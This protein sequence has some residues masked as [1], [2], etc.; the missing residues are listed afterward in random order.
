MLSAFSSAA[1]GVVRA[2]FGQ[3]TGTIWLDN[4]DCVGSEGT[5]IQCPANAFGR[6][7]CDHSEDAGVRCLSKPEK[8][9]ISVLSIYICVTWLLSL[10]SSMCSR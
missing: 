2:G 5:L 10:C 8:E 9:A 4:V 6:H 7:N 3:G 1:I